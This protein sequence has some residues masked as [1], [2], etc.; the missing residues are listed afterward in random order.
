MSLVTKVNDLA[1]R[2]AEEFVTVRSEI[3]GVSQ[4]GNVDGGGPSTVFSTGQGILDGGAP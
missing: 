1:V 3:S 2:V 4:G